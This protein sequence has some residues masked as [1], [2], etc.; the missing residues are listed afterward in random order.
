MK[1]LSSPLE[2]IQKSFNIFFEK[3]N[4]V[5]FAKIYALLLP[6][7]LFFTYQNYFVS[8]QSK[9]LNIT[10][11]QEIIMKY[12]WFL[13]SVIVA[14][15]V[16]L[17][18]SFWVDMAGIKAILG[19]T[20]GKKVDVNE[21]LKFSLKNIPTF[22]LL[23]VV[24]GLIQ[25]GGLIL[26]IVPGIIFGVWYSFSKFLFVEKKLSIMESLKES[27]KLVLGR[28]W[29]IIGRLFVFG[30]FSGLSG[31]IIS[32]VPYIGPLV[33]PFFGAL[34]ILPAFLLYKEL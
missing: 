34:F 19:I 8:T 13:A 3:D 32:S 24:L 15:L 17:F 6:F 16:Y 14:N 28:F 20:S 7:Q 21:A 10:N 23:V 5:V 31:A 22:S 9:I 2:I 1:K 18:I 12:P 27:K 30:L 11:P 25:I 26:L 29:K 33:V 4:M